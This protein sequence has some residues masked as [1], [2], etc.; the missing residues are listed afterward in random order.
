VEYYSRQLCTPHRAEQ[1]IYQN[2]YV[3]PSLFIF[4]SLDLC[5]LRVLSW[6]LRMFPT[7][8]THNPEASSI[9]H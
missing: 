4:L 6:I 2:Q 3:T 9:T 8:S 1:A 7:T 5:S